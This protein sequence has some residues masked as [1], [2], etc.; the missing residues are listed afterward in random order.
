MFSTQPRKATLVALMAMASY[1]AGC[2]RA[3]EA[4]SDRAEKITR[5]APVPVAV[6]AAQEALLRSTSSDPQAQRRA[7]DLYRQLVDARALTCSTGVDV[8][9][10][11]TVEVVRGK[12]VNKACFQE[13]DAEMAAWIGARRVGVELA[14]API[15]AW[16]PTERRLVIPAPGK[17]VA[18]VVAAANAN[19]V[20]AFDSDVATAI[21]IPSG[22]TIGTMRIGGAS[23]T[24]AQLSPN[25]RLLALPIGGRSLEIFDVESGDSIW[26]T[27]QF[28]EVVAWLPEA[29]AL[30]LRTRDST[31]LLLD[32]RSAKAQPFA[33][34]DASPTWSV[35]APG[36]PRRVLVG[37][38]Y[39]ATLIEY[40]RDAQGQLTINP[41][42]QW[43]LPPPGVTSSWPLLMD[44]GRKLVFKS[45]RDLAWFDLES[46]QGG[47]W[48][49]S[50]VGGLGFTKL[51]ETTVLFDMSIGM[52]R[53]TRLLDIVSATVSTVPVEEVEAGLLWPTAAPQGYVRRGHRSIAVGSSVSADKAQPLDRFLADALMEQQL[54]FMKSQA[55][56]A[57]PSRSAAAAA[58][59]AT[60]PVV[61]APMLSDIPADAQV[62]VVGVYE[63]SNRVRVPGNPRAGSGSVRITLTPGR[64]PLVLVLSNYEA[65]RWIVQGD[66]KIAA[67]LLSGYGDSSVIGPGSDKSVRI[68]STHAY[69]MDSPEYQK[70]K[71]D[72]ARY[73]ANPVRVFQGKYS[74]SEF[75]V[76][77]L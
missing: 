5:A 58:P 69:S 55:A 20:V 62:M 57:D 36:D 12:L 22:K 60:R 68:G 61:Q 21:A 19:V 3:K 41:V 34:S 29:E 16:S 53:G 56:S 35:P 10:L 43:R 64:A 7:Q 1:L 25:G 24:Q 48:P 52:A 77:T 71:Q 15:A 28:S 23:T 54:A 44:S 65:T 18:S 32:T 50:Q 67:V 45:M 75:T 63:P 72:I 13:R 11:D 47:V 51:S 39:S 74:A 49:L 70:L 59:F 31:A 30:L 4:L 2:D 76:G 46:G 26:K 8:G 17:Q 37:T 6:Q 14:R 73:V 66:R 33:A 9:R 38:A 27:D 40:A 42:R